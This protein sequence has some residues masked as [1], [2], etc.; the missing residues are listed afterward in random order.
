M[1]PSSMSVTDRSAPSPARLRASALVAA[2]ALGSVVMWVAIPAAW[3]LLAAQVSETRPTLMPLL[4]IFAGT[5]LTMLPAAK[6]LG[7]LDRRHQE[8]AGTVDDR[9]RH[10]PWHRSM[11]DEDDGGAPR[12]V[13]AVV[14]VSSVAVAFAALGVWFFLFAGSSLPSA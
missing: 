5:P 12:S 2:M 13:L 8:L 1:P 4:M 3:I 11:R 6:L 14:M 7:V 9:R 10:E